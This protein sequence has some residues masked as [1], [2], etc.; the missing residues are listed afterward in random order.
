MIDKENKTQTA[1]LPK[2]GTSS[3][4]LGVAEYYIENGYVVFTEAYHLKRGHCCKNS[5]RHCPYGYRKRP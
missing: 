4:E 5:C 3:V 2:E 1:I